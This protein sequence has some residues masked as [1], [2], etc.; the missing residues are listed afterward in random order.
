MCLNVRMRKKKKKK[1]KNIQTCVAGSEINASSST[2]AR[3]IVYDA[4]TSI[5]KIKSGE[6]IEK[7][8]ELK[9]TLKAYSFLSAYY[10]LFDS[11]RS[12]YSAL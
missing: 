7:K 3:A 12:R 6:P 10:R 11:I 5:K 2:P 4:C 1:K 8:R 9:N